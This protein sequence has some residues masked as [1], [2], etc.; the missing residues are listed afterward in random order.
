MSIEGELARAGIITTDAGTILTKATEIVGD[1]DVQGTATFVDVVSIDGDLIVNGVFTGKVAGTYTL[2]INLADLTDTGLAK[3]YAV[4]PT[5]GD[6]Y[7]SR[8]Y[9][10]LQ[11]D[12]GTAGNDCTL[13]FNTETGLLTSEN[14]IVI[15][16]S[17]VAGTVNE[18]IAIPSTIANNR[19]EE[20]EAIWI[21]VA[22]GTALPVT[23]TVIIEITKS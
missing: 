21:D 7:I 6:G 2:Q 4:I 20:G 14:D 11:A 8:A 17:S 23:G 16:D 15:L 5:G 12:G 18:T 13:S 10:I 9:H 22:G 3:G 1:L 19:V